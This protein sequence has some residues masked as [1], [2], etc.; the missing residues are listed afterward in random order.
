MIAARYPNKQDHENKKEVS[1]GAEL[2][3]LARNSPVYSV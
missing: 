3:D 2:L 1:Q